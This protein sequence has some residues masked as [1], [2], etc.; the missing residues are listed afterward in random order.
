MDQEVLKYYHNHQMSEDELEYLKQLNITPDQL[1]KFREKDKARL[2]YINNI[3]YCLIAMGYL[4][5]SDG[6]EPTHFFIRE[7]FP[8]YDASFVKEYILNKIANS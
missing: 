6:T 1:E 8:T 3:G 4:I 2:L 7:G 5:M